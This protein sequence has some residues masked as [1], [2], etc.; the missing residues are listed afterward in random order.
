MVG[1]NILEHPK[2]AGW[3][4]LAPTSTELNLLHW[5]RVYEYIASHNPDIVIHGAALVGGIQANIENPIAYLDNNLIMGRNVIMA[6]HQCGVDK[7]INI[8]STCIYPR[9][10]LNPLREN[11]ILSGELEPTNEGYALA[12]ILAIKLCQYIHRQDKGKHYKSVIACNLFGRHDKYGKHHSHLIAAIIDKIHRA[13]RVGDKTVEIWGDGSARRE[14]MY[15]GDFADALLRAA[16]DVT[17]VPEII[18]IAKGV[19]L[20]IVAYYRAV[21]DVV[22]W[23]GSFVYDLS[24]PVGMTQKLASIELQK[25]W[26]WQARTGLLDGISMA[27]ECY[28]DDIAV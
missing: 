8:S 13:K 27:Y 4:I 3:N 24:K 15:V 5:E 26:G 12:K 20:P 22:G 9:L 17:N 23:K 10:A 28:L 16:S 14:F 7:L 25:R 2:R 1:R 6:A 19:D 21:A 11:M 18:N